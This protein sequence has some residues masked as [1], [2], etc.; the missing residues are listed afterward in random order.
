MSFWNIEPNN[1]FIGARRLLPSL[2]RESGSSFFDDVLTN[3]EE[4]AKEIEH[5]GKQAPKGLVTEYETSDGT[6]VRKVGPIVYGYSMTVGPDGKPVIR[7][8][9]NVKRAPRDGLTTQTEPSRPDIGQE[10]EPM[11][12]VLGTD[13]EVKVTVE[14]PGVDKGKIKIDAYD[15]TVEV[16]SMDPAR[17]YHKVIDLPTEAD[18]ETARSNY[19]NGILEITFNKKKETKPKGKQIKIE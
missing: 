16:N 10:R 8:F 19:N 3:F 7:E 17:K 11:I 9:G 1:W 13:T 14:M 4:M 18:V 5:V 6:K 15:N 12:D 2:N